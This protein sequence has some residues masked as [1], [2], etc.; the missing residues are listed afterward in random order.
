MVSLGALLGLLVSGKFARV[1][2]IDRTSLFLAILCI[3]CPFLTAFTNQDPIVNRLLFF[4]GLT[5]YDGLSMAA[6]AA[7]DLIPF[8]LGATVLSDEAGRKALLRTMIVAMLLYSLPIL[9]EVRLSP[10]FHRWVYGIHPHEFQQQVRDGAFRAT[11][12]LKHGLVVAIFLAM[13]V[14]A[15]FGSRAWRARISGVSTAVAG[16]YLTAILVLQKSLGALVFGVFGAAITLLTRPRMQMLVAAGIG[17]LVLSY[18]VVRGSGLLPIATIKEA[19]ASYNADRASSLN[20]RLENEDRLLAKANERPLA[21][22]GGWGRNRIFDAYSGRDLTVTDGMWIIIIGAFGWI[23]YLTRF[24]LLILPLLRGGA[25]VLRGKAISPE[26]AVLSLVLAINLL[27]LLPNSSLTPVTWLM[28][29]ALCGIGQA[30]RS[31]AVVQSDEERA[32]DEQEKAAPGDAE[33]NLG[34]I[35]VPHGGVVARMRP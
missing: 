16:V 11:V 3:A 9:V 1:R 14:T 26:V 32:A 31:S 30:R 21:G 5:A 22:W 25:T 33:Q 4:N 20:L 17:A 29:G 35:R 12:F 15:A 24:G 10:Q 13:S 19:A 23:G 18:P 7:I 6:Q 28:A 34:P 2:K 27:D 8:W